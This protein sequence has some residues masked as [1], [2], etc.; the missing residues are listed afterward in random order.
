MIR[1]VPFDRDWVLE[2]KDWEIDRREMNGWIERW[3]DGYIDQ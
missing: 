2:K 1:G 3:I